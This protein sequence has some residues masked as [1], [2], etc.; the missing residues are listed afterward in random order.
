MTEDVYR[1]LCDT[2]SKRGGRYP[3]RDMPQFY[4]M[5]RVLFTEEEAAV[6]N[7]MPRGF[8]TAAAI[9]EAMGRTAE[10]VAPILESMADKGLCSAGELQGTRFYGGLP[11]VPGIFEF[12]FLRGTNTERDRRLAKLIRDYKEAFDAREGPPRITFPGERVS[13]SIG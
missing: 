12:Q 7:A 13:R 6:S 5:A 9:A 2:M 4:A 11:F 10:E 3:G 1:R 8:N